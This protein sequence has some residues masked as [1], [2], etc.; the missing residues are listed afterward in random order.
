MM[1]LAN[2]F[3]PLSKQMHYSFPFFCHLLKKIIT[4]TE[5]TFKKRKK[6][7]L[8][9]CGMVKQITDNLE[10]ETHKNKSF[11]WSLIMIII[12]PSL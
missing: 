1:D 4:R 8:E 9:G 2:G 3:P 6:G 11:V 7:Q 5:T 10:D 12:V